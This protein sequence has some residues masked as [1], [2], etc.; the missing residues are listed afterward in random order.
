MKTHYEKII[1][2]DGAKFIE[3]CKAVASFHGKPDLGKIDFY[4]EAAKPLFPKSFSDGN[5]AATV[6][7]CLMFYAL[8]SGKIYRLAND[9]ASEL[10][11]VAITVKAKCLP[12]TKEVISIQL[13]EWCG[14]EAAYISGVKNLGEDSKGKVFYR[15]EFQLCNL[16]QYADN[17]DRAVMHFYDEEQTIDNALDF[18]ENPTIPRDL[19]KFL[20]NVYLYIH[21]GEPDLRSLLPEPK[22]LSKKPKVIRRYEKKLEKEGSLPVILVGFNFKKSTEVAAHF[23]GYWIGTGRS[24]LV[25][26][27][28]QQYRKGTAII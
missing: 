21:S 13:P 27:W 19:I 3:I 20:V 26:K 9:F 22:P 1:K 6:L 2:S 25:L 28:K 15:L 7:R 18:F 12:D 14:Y 11:K 10:R 4:Q 8:F 5:D 23:Q 24:T 16:D 17:W